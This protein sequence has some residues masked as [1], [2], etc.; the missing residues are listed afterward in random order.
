MTITIKTP[1]ESNRQAWE[2]L[3]RGYAAFY[4]IP[5]IDTTLHTVE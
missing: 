5:I 4:K 1:D 2:P 3:Y